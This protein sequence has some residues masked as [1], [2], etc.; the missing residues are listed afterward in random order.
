MSMASVSLG[1]WSTRVGGRSEGVPLGS[2][3]RARSG[4]HL[5]LATAAVLILEYRFFW[6]TRGALREAEPDLRP[7]AGTPRAAEHCRSGFCQETRHTLHAVCVSQ[8]PLGRRSVLCVVWDF[9]SPSWDWQGRGGQPEALGM[10][11]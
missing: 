7:R 9:S 10:L 5:R 6:K 8:V 2:F 3:G 1:R 11:G 4:A